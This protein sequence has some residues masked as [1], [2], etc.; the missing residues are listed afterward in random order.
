MDD[1]RLDGQVAVITG[2]GRGIGRSL[3]RLFDAAGAR[4]ATCA[5]GDE[6]LQRVAAEVRA[7]GGTVLPVVA[8]LTVEADITRFADRVIAEF[9]AVDILVNCAG[10]NTRIATARVSDTDPADW[11]H[12]MDLNYFATYLLTRA[13]LPHM[14]RGGHVINFGSG[15]GHRAGASEIG[16]RA[17]KAAV[18]MFTRSLALEVWED[19]IAVNELVPGAVATTGLN[20][21]RDRSSDATVQAELEGTFLGPEIIRH[22]DVPAEM[23]LWLASRPPGGPT[24][25]TFSLH[26]EPH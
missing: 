14:P 24:G 13:L 23:A 2:G 7:A 20:L 4:V 18:S 5:R 19:G 9:G 17:A 12:V 26:R 1:L 3:V 15:A 22:P 6:Q 25:Q 21:G 10:G 8:D 16:Y 11:R